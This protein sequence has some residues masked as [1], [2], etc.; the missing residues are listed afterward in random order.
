MDS[1]AIYTHYFNLWQIHCLALQHY[2]PGTPP[3]LLLDAHHIRKAHA[4]SIP[5]SIPPNVWLIT[6]APSTVMTGI[7]LVCP[8]GPTKLITIWKPIHILQLPPA[9]S[10]T[11]PYFYLPPHYEATTVAINISLE[12]A[13]LNMINILAMDFHVW[14]HLENH[15]NES[16]LQ[17]LDSIL[18]LQLIS[19]TDT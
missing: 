8:E 7:T 16:Q 6:S 18:W 15:Q 9:C 11:S 4:I 3:A 2:T 5:T 10:T 19:T 14:Q 13:N 1:S 12:V 17:H